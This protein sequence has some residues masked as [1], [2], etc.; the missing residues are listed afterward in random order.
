MK[1]TRYKLTQMHDKEWDF[2][3]IYFDRVNLLVGDS[4]TGKTRL[5]NTILNFSK[6]L[7]SEKVIFPGDWDI[8]FIIKEKEYRYKLVVVN[9][10]ENP[11][12]KIILSEYL[13]NETD[14][15]EL[16]KRDSDAFIW[17]KT[18]LPK[19][20]RNIVSVFLLKEE[21]EIKP[22]FEGYQRV[23]ARRF[24]LDALSSNFGI[25]PIVPEIHKKIIETKNIQA[26]IVE[27]MNFPIKMYLLKSINLNLYSEAIKLF[28]EAFP[29]IEDFRIQPITQIVDGLGVPINSIS[30]QIKEKNINEWIPVNDISSGMQKLFLLI[31]DTVL[32]K[33]G[34]ILLIDEY[35][36]SLGIN[37]I[38]YLPELLYSISS[39]CQFILT[40][41]HPYIINNIPIEDWMVFHRNGYKVHI[42]S[43]KIFKDKYG[44]SKQQNF[45]QLIN[46]P[47][48]L[49]GIE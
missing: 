3:E 37:A 30:F 21:N 18:E 38:N 26:L 39:E 2:D 22:I 20:G 13:V 48:Y 40:S 31:L 33:D 8:S 11:G 17:K 49:K 47:F 4:G 36:N 12:D 16:I 7:V 14:G 28:K 19:L 43:G 15:I 34:G 5:L 46:D 6:Q 27:E 23:V 9:D 24:S 44:K 10:I 1:I 32:L 25:G 41:H 42:R 29:F 35:E 45:I